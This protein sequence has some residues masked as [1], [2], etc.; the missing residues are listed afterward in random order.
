MKS[1]IV[2]NWKQ[3]PTNQKEAKQL[4]DAVKKGVKNSNA[5]VV[6]C[7]PFIYLPLLKAK[8]GT[9]LH[10]PKP[11]TGL[12]LGAQNIHF[13]EKGAF[14]GEISAL[15]LKDLGIEY[16]IIGHSE[17]RKYFGETNEIINKKIKTA[18]EAG[19]K[20]IFCIGENAGQDKPAVLE[21]QITKGL[22]GVSNVKHQMSHVIIAYE[23]VWAIGTG[24]NC[25]IED[26]RHAVALIKNRMLNLYDN[27]LVKEMPILYGGSVNSGNSGE[28]LKDAEVNGLLVGGASLNAQEF[29]KIVKSAP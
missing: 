12:Y 17:R 27:T 1:I 13:E 25:S 2:A 8:A 10:L 28:Y 19:L 9:V 24:K 4:F 22:R 16:V 26:T 23:P 20:V 21:E 11:G 7:P 14:T 29:I 18:L 3:N 6:I 15:Q 5:D